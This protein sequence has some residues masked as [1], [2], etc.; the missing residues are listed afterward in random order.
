[1]DLDELKKLIKTQN[2]QITA[3]IQAETANSRLKEELQSTTRKLEKVYADLK[4]AE[5]R[6]A[7]VKSEAS[8]VLAEA[9]QEATNMVES[10]KLTKAEADRK[11]SE[12]SRLERQAQAKLDEAQDLSGRYQSLIADLNAQKEKILAAIK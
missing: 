6:L 8:H 3:L 5:D 4:V 7:S 9:N 10:A 12:A 2:D 11:L 1:M